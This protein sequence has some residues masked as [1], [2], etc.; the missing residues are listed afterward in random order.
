MI[1]LARSLPVNPPG[2]THPVTRADVWRGLALKADNALPF[3][4]SITYCKV[5]ERDS[6]TRFVR[7]IEFRGDR[8]IERV[9]LDP[10]TEV[11]FERLS[12]PVLGTIR[13]VIEEDAS[14][15]LSLRFE[16]ELELRGA[17]AGSPAEL[18]HAAAMENAYLGA[19]DA[20]L[21]A[22]RKLHDLAPVS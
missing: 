4:P 18:A 11:T 19:V 9:T 6:P 5:L 3:V 22:I 2:T 8:M 12:G 21:A 1:K 16:F 20:T 13:N 7:E 17:A 14:G 10:E 15:E